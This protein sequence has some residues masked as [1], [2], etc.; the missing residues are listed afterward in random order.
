MYKNSRKNIHTPLIITNLHMKVAGGCMALLEQ[1]TD[2][3]YTN[4]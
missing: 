4:H 2:L 3:L 1:H